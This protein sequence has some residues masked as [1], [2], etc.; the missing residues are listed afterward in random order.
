VF[1]YDV[2]SELAVTVADYVGAGWSVGEPVIVIATT[3]HLAAIDAALSN[4]GVDVSLARARGSYLSLD[5][6]E[7]LDAFMVHGSPDADRFRRVV[8]GMLDDARVDGI[9][10]RAFGEMVA[11][12]WH[13]GNV[14]G[15]MALESS[16]NEFAEHQQFS[17]LCAYPTTALGTAELSDVNRVCHL[18][19]GVLPPTSYGSASTGGVE[20]AAATA[21]RVFVAAPEAVYAARHFISETLTSW[22]E[23]ELGWDGALI[24]SELATNAIIH[25]GSAFRASIERTANVVRIAIEDV[26]PGLPQSRRAFHSALDGRGLAIVEELSDRWGC[27]RLDDGKAFWVELQSSS[28]QPR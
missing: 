16:W 27:D 6:A 19:S 7:T 21:S 25:G 9:P 23:N 24:I 15:A 20:S 11:L 18:H 14:A 28:A 2:A 10:V 5:A 1:F 13:Q 12:L 26:G 3:P 22:G 8:G 17:L 4:N